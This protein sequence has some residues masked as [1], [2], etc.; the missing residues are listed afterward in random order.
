M[1]NKC[2]IPMYITLKQLNK[3]N[4]MKTEPMQIKKQKKIL[5]I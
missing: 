3:P 2:K 4:T 5:A 1:E